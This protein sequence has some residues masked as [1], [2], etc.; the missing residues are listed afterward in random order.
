MWSKQQTRKSRLK[1]GSK[2]TIWRQAL[3]LSY[4][5]S[6]LLSSLCPLRE[7]AVVVGASAGV[8]LFLGL[9]S[10]VCL[11]NP[12]FWSPWHARSISYYAVKFFIKYTWKVECLLCKFFL[13]CPNY[14]LQL[15]YLHQKRAGV[16]MQRLFHSSFKSLFTKSSSWQLLCPKVDSICSHPV[17]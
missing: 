15:N 8:L 12:Y 10:F 13:I 11:T 6:S 17:W 7:D 16:E 5:L 9:L 2:R 1:F 14:K 3:R 4:C